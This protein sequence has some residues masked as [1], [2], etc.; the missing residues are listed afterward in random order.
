[1]TAERV[2]AQRAERYSP[3]G[4]FI[5][6]FGTVPL[7]YILCTLSVPSLYPLYTPLC[8]YPLCIQSVPTLQPLHTSPP[9]PLYPLR[10]L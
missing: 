2:N 6:S 1:M 5:G 9:P 10:I 4:F 3:L 8:I 7:K